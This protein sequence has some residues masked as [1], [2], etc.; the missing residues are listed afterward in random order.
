MTVEYVD[1]DREPDRARR[2]PRSSRYGTI[3]I[4]YKDRTER[5]TST[6]EQDLTNA[7]IKA[8]TGATRRST[9]RR[10]TARR[11]PRARIGPATAPSSQA[12]GRDNYGVEQLVLAQQRD[13][14]ADA[15]VAGHRRAADRISC[16]RR[17]TR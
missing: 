17:S 8:V 15:T 2:R 12:L 1:A 3:V 13:V 6:D 11:T 5:V 10:A 14:P 9:S 16:S 7:L 4:D